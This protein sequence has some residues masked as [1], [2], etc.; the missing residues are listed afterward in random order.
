MMIKRLKKLNDALLRAHKN[1]GGKISIAPKIHLS[2]KRKLNIYY[3]PGVGSVASFIATHKNDA[4]KMT[5]KR[6]SVAI[7]SDGSAVLGL[8]NIGPEAA[9]PVMEGKAMIFKEFADIDAF[10]IVLDTQKT[11]E[12]VRAVK[13]IAPVFGGINLEDIAAPRCFEI[14]KRLR[15]SLNIP[16]VHD[17]Q[18]ATAI[19]V[20]AGLI[21][22]FKV[23]KK[24]FSKSKIVV[25]GAGAAGNAIVK[26][27][28]RYGAGNVIVLDRKGIIRKNRPALDIYK[29]ELA[30]ITNKYN[31]TGDLAAAIKN[32][33]AFVG[34]SG[35]GLLP[36]AYI[37]SMAPRPVVFAL[38]NPT[39]EIMPAKAKSA[40]AAVVAT[41]RSDYP[42]QINNALVFPGLFRG[43][44]DHQVKNLTDKMKIRAALKIAAL[45]KKPTSQKI[46]PAI[47]DKRIV[48]TIAGAIR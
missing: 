24:T 25:L 7:V 15:K 38:A 23:V 4:R 5:I 21:N 37:K 35:P 1:L 40:G 13:W 36:P 11:D 43:L 3:T 41:G 44:L 18:H 26:I 45:V 46:I 34:I 33:D 12:I 27:L 47:F 17:D 19:I 48:K 39:P 31:E 2:S 42:N 16:V 30:R 22:A 28:V 14:E 20:L 29:K 9:I 8:G 32:A 6:N 10:P